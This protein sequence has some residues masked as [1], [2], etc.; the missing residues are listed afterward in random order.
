MNRHP[1]LDTPGPVPFAHRGG[2]LEAAENTLAAFAHAVRLGYRHIETDVHATRDGVLLVFHDDTLDRLTGLPGR[3]GDYRWEELR[4]AKVQGGEGIPLFDALLESFPDTRFNIDPKTDAAADALAAA[5]D[6][7]QAFGRVCV[8]SFSGGRLARLRQRFGPRLCTS[9]GPLEV[10]RNWLA[11]K[12]LPVDP[13]APDCFQVPVRQYGV[14]I[15]TPAFLRAAHAAGKPVHVWTIDDAVEM[16]RLLELG[17]DGI[18][19]D[20]PTLL[21][22]VMEGRGVWPRPSF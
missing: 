10:A 19:T 14:E 1:Y 4:D 21:R 8:G 20:R 12:G 16:G 22:E 17:V 6:R 3:P 2:G 13:S 5:L 11:G 15:V 9:A 7:H 18:M